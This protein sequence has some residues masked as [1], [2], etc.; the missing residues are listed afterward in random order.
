MNDTIKGNVLI[1]EL[2]EWEKGTSI[3]KYFHP[4]TR[5]H[6]Q[7]RDTIK[8][9][10]LLPKDHPIVE[11]MYTDRPGFEWQKD[12]LVVE[13]EDL[14]FDRNWNWLMPVVEK[15][16]KMKFPELASNFS[17]EY[18]SVKITGCYVDKDENW[19]Y[20]A[21]IL[22]TTNTVG[23]PVREKTMIQA[24]YKAVVEFIKW[25]KSKN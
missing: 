18:G 21:S 16:E 22:L 13:F 24:T 9:V 2:L 19:A 8:E 23:K 6:I 7:S 20:R 25:Y 14:E 4:V 12:K 15:I 11:E 3:E 10:F 5:Q 1:A 17:P